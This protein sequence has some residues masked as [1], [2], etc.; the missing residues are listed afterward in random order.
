M[1]FVGREQ[2]LER[3][4][5]WW[6]TSERFALVWGR[7]RVGKTALVHRFA[8]GKRTIF[9][10]GGGESPRQE[11]AGLSRRTAEAFPSDLR[12]LAAHPY[13]DWHDALDHLARLA[14]DEPVLLVLDEFPELLIGYPALPGV[15]RAFWDR[16]QGET[17]LRVLLCGSSVRTMFSI[18]ETRAPLYGRFDLA[19]PVHPFRPH[20]AAAMLRDLRPSDRAA[21]YG[22]VGGMPLY[23]SWWDQHRGVGENL[24]ELACRPGARLLSEGRLVLATEVGEGEQPA[25]VLRAIA[26][27]RTKFHE[28]SDAVGANPA[29]ALD[30]LIELR[31]VERVLPVTE[32]ERSR[33]RIYRICDN[34][35]SFYLG[36][37]MRYRA[38]IELDMGESIV[39]ALLARIDDHM[40]AAYEEAFRDH[41][42]RLA[43]R[44]SLGPRV[45]AIGPWWRGDGGDQIDAVVMAEPKRTRIPTLVGEAKWATTVNASRLRAR[46]YEKAGSLTE[47]R[48]ELT[49]AVC[50]RE[51]VAHGDPDVLAITAAEI[52]AE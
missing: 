27:G 25:A 3:L 28:I 51:T 26:S 6:S 47:R 48:D 10:T 37:L 7:R 36:P 12:D 18:Q 49:Y 40:G 34:F 4:E 16:A 43:T 42:R 31:L 41:L 14:R 52:F 50:A 30:R 22:L 39:G 46:L 2:E 24:L 35:L 29:R 19:L 11:L 5:R 9:H 38:E 32:T 8:G 23:L 20:E 45:V 1:E 17:M 21:V 33:R 44:G 13:Y 15:L